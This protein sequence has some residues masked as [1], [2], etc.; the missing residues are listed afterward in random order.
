MARMRVFMVFVLAI[1]AGGALAFGTYNFVQ[2]TRPRTVSIP[3]RP[4]VVAA[5]D[6]DIGA[7]LRRDDIRI[8][9]WPANA[10]PAGAIGDPK[11]VIGRSI[12]LPVIQNEPILPMKLASA[13][14]GSGLPP[15]IPPGLRAVSVR[16]NE[17]IGVAG[18]VL[19]AT[20]VDVLATVSPT[21]QNT[22][23]TSKVILTNVQVLAAGTKI[24]R[25]TDKGKPLAVSVVTLLV[26]P[27]EAERLTLASTEGKIQLALRNPLDKT[28]PETHGIRPAALFGFG[29]PTRTAVAR[30]RVA[31][32]SPSAPVVAAPPELP[33]VEII[34]GDK[35]AHEVVRQE[36]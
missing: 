17:V 1:S 31:S 25:D 18:Y 5:A 10:V 16:V 27:E 35:R 20:R 36:Q 28:M 2:N 34:R 12:V 24:E 30:S 8:I 13:E 9:D 26:A 23:M 29:A 15:A 4:V 22:D 3:T 19:P 14:A 32:A 6:L 33:T 7:E 11:D 21:G